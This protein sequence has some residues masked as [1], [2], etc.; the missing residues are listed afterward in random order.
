MS[1]PPPYEPPEDA[2]LRAALDGLRLDEYHDWDEKGL[3]V[4]ER[5]TGYGLHRDDVERIEATGVGYR[6][7][8]EPGSSPSP[9]PR[10][11]LP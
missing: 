11:R 8:R 1:L 3:V 10:G 9:A 7:L 6:I 5:F 2:E 4:V